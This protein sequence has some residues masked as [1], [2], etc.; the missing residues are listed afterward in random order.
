[1][2]AK[3][4]F[5][6]EKNGKVAFSS[7]RVRLLEAVGETGSISAAASRMGVS[8]RRAWDKIH[9]C[10]ERLGIKLVETQTGG[11]GGGGSQ[12]TPAALEYIQR[13]HNFA[14]GLQTMVGIQFQEYFLKDQPG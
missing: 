10:E 1:M 14:D 3:A 2:Q 12:L 13:F 7:W 5:W 6:I 11:S 8:Y 9:E 4:N